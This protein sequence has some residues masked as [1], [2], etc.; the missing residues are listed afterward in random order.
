MIGSTRRR[1]WSF[2]ETFPHRRRRGTPSPHES[3]EITPRASLILLARSQP[4]RG[5]TAKRAG[6]GTARE[7]NPLMA[8]N[9]ETATP[10]LPHSQPPQP[11]RLLLL[12]IACT[13]P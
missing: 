11:P 7:T 9:E 12:C 1:P 4:L 10:P 13:S 5:A 2:D 3:P 8:V 6:G